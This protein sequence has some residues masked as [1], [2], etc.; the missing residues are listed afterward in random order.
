VPSQTATSSGGPDSPG[1]G[2]SDGQYGESFDDGVPSTQYASGVDA[3]AIANARR[4]LLHSEPTAFSIVHPGSAVG[5]QLWT[6]GPLVIVLLVL[7]LGGV[8]LIPALF[9]L[10]R[11]RGRW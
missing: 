9:A 8:L 5:V 3:A 2:S 10:G 4:R 7:A 6:G 1:D 11:R